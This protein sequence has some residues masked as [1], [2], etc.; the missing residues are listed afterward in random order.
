MLPTFCSVNYD[1]IN[2]PIGG[3]ARPLNDQ[4]LN[5][6]NAQFRVMKKDQLSFA[7]D[8]TKATYQVGMLNYRPNF[9]DHGEC[10]RYT[11]GFPYANVALDTLFIPAVYAGP[12]NPVNVLGNPV[13]KSRGREPTRLANPKP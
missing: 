6:V 12:W 3:F 2:V 9:A 4:A 11:H 13:D 1:H 5:F 8:P 7:Q 10:D